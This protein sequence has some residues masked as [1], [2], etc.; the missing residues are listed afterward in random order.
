MDLPVE[1]QCAEFCSDPLFLGPLGGLAYKIYA[2]EAAHLGYGLAIFLL[3]SLP[4][5]LTRW[6]SYERTSETASPRAG[7]FTMSTN[8][9]ESGRRLTS[10]FHRRR[11]RRRSRHDRRISSLGAS[12]HLPSSAGRRNPDRSGHR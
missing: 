8:R 12:P 9:C 11:R 4:A 2:V 1:K 7:R 3:I 6:Y 5:R 10:D